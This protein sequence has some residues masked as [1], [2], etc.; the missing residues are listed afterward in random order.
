L[1]FRQLSIAKTAYV[2]TM[3][4]L[5]WPGNYCHAWAK[6]YII[7]ENHSYQR[8]TPHGEQVLVWYHAEIR[9]NWY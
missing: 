8:V 2:Q 9:R 3:T 6:F 7:L 1:S 4:D 5:D